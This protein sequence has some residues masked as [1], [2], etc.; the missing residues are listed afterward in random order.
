[1]TLK[2]FMTNFSIES[3]SLI[4]KRTFG[5]FVTVLLPELGI[6]PSNAALKSGILSV[7]SPLLRFKMKDVRSPTG[8]PKV[9]NRGPNAVFRVIFLKA[10]F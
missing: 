9:T 7:T 3:R 5:N 4:R 2:R 6:E 10:F 1:M 8:V